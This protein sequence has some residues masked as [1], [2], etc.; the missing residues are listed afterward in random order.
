[1]TPRLWDDTVDAHRRSVRE[2]TLDATAELV[3]EHGIAAVTMSRIAA[4]TGIGRATLYKYF[5]DVESILVAWHERQITQHLTLLGEARER[6]RDARGRL[7]SVLTAYARLARESH[8]V[9]PA[10]LLHSREHVTHAHQ[11]LVALVAELIRDGAE[12]GDFRDDV[13]A[14]EL[15]AFCLGALGSLGMAGA[16]SSESSARRLVAVTVGALERRASTG[17][18]TR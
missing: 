11:H 12:R 13:P 17:Q 1:V 2:A 4:R 18:G 7:T 14:K 9:D 5:P 3:A 10:G 6:G 16:R 15:A 8:G